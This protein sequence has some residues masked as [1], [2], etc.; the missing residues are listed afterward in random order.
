MAQILDD[1]TRQNETDPYGIQ[2]SGY[3]EVRT[4]SFVGGEI[5]AVT[6][7]LNAGTQQ[8]ASVGTVG[9]PA[10]SSSTP[11][12]VQ[13]ISKL[14]GIG[15]P[16]DKPSVYG[17]LGDPSG[18]LGGAGETLG[19][20]LFNPAEFIAPGGSGSTISKV[21]NPVGA[22]FC[23]VAGTLIRMSDGTLKAVEEIELGDDLM[24]GGD[25][26]GRGEAYGVD[27]RHYRG[28]VVE[29]N[30]AVFE[31]GK[32][33]RVRD[34]I[35]GQLRFVGDARVYPIVTMTHVMV[36]KT[37][38]AADFA[39]IEDAYHINDAQRIEALNADLD[40]CRWLTDMEHSLRLRADV[41]A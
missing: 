4:P 38:I 34:S 9:A 25:V 1:P 11:D 32:F 18:M 33:I 22:I 10:P 35:H 37:H 3:S 27:L 23:Y 36:L 24:L 29:S 40:R 30:H 14:A 16:S 19:K 2:S 8:G 17:M 13:P 26:L 5:D 39:E 28:T 41:A 21:L 7:N 31:D 12:P 15:Q 20:A 6:G